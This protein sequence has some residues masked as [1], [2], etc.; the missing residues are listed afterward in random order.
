MITNTTITLLS[1]MKSRF[2]LNKV[3]SS[4]SVYLIENRKINFN[5]FSPVYF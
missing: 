3:K 2:L 1:A 4:K 5:A